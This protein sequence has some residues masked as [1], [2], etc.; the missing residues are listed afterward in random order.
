MAW[1][2]PRSSDAAI[3]GWVR[4][5]GRPGFIFRSRIHL[6]GAFNLEDD[7]GLDQREPV[8]HARLEFMTTP[9]QGVALEYFGYGRENGAQ[10]ARTI[11]YQTRIRLTRER[12]FHD[13]RLDLRLRGPTLFLRMR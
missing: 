1:S 5:R 3:P 6:E 7:L 13:T 8:L 11:T 9:S 2:C 10:L 12:E 4:S